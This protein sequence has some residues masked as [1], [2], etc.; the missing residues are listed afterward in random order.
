MAM[1][2]SIDDSTIDAP[3][4]PFATAP[5]IPR[6]SWPT[7][8]GI[9]CLSLGSLGIVYGVLGMIWAVGW[10]MMIRSMPESP[11]AGLPSVITLST[12]LSGCVA[13]LM[14]GLLVWGG[15][16]LASRKVFGRAVLLWWSALEIVRVPI[17]TILSTTMSQTILELISRP[18]KASVTEEQA[19]AM[20]RALRAMMVAVGILGAV[21]ALIL[22]VF[23]LVWLNRDLIRREVGL[24]RESSISH[25]SGAST[26]NGQA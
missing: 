19:A 9:I 26:V 7:I 5:L 11:G 18:M 2:E 23:L 15:F 16:G 3:H 8:V 24:W 17:A 22:P 12:I 25:R 21:L 14:Y 4:G 6:T 20:G 1:G 10:T 13:L